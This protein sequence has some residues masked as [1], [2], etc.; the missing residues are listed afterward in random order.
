M[1]PIKDEQKV[2]LFGSG[3]KAFV[4]GGTGS[5]DVNSRH[6][7]SIMEGLE[8]AGVQVMNMEEA[9]RFQADHEAAMA[10]YKTRVLM[11]LE[12]ISYLKKRKTKLL[13]YPNIQ[14]N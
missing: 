10:D 9:K 14:I 6:V 11:H 13:N 5:G 4:K 3:V 1:L 12:I 2:L 7:V 8:N